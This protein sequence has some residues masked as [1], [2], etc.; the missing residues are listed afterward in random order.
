MHGQLFMSMHE[1]IEQADVNR[2]LWEGETGGV[3]YK[4]LGLL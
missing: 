3:I 2:Q 1:D 4:Y